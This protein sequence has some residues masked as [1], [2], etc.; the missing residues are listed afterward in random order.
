MKSDLP[1]NDLSH[2]SKEEFLTLCPQGEHAP[3]AEPL[4]IA[5]QAVMT[6]ATN[7][8]FNVVNDP[9]YKQCIAAALHAAADQVVPITD[10]PEWFSR[11]CCERSVEIARNCVLAE[12]LAIAAELEGQP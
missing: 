7:G 8:N 5:A 12:L 1:I 10:D 9:V 3:G 11:N 4:S 2:L 6:A